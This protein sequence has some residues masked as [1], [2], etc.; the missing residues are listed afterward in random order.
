M[1]TR[2]PSPMDTVDL[3]RGVSW[4]TDLLLTTGSGISLHSSSTA[5]AAHL[6]QANLSEAPRPRHTCVASGISAPPR[7]KISPATIHRSA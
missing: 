6:A 2:E 1:P 3:A 5:P 7:V 4:R